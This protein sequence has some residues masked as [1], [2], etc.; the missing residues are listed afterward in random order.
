MSGVEHIHVQPDEEGMRLDR[1]FRAH[2][3]ELGHGALQKL[4]R[5]GQVRL[6]G[7]RAKANARIIPGQT[8]RVP[9]VSRSERT[10]APKPARPPIDEAVAESLRE[11]VIHIDDAIV[12]LNKQAGLAVQG[13]T[14]TTHHIDGMLDALTFGAPERPRLVH[15]LDRDTSGIL[16]LARTRRAAAALASSFKSRE[17]RK[18]YWALVSGVP[19]PSSGRIDAPL[20]KV[21]RAG[22]QRMIVDEEGAK[23]A[24][25]AVTD[26]ATID[27]AARKF[28]WLAMSPLTGRTHQLRVHC[29]TIGCPIVGDRKYGAEVSAPVDGIARGMHLHARSI[30]I[31]HPDGGVLKVSAEMP[32]HMRESWRFLEFDP[33]SDQALDPFN[34]ELAGF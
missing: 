30:A 17:T 24:L 28:S 18:I 20:I 27:H 3:P 32:D 12:V 9:P 8:V 22:D 4:L 7:A 34:D 26:F 14:K 25:S 1:W 11:L 19:R 23:A 5:S 29:A 10:A 13:G 2:Y 21:G 15:R 6:D 31:A 33:R 16:L